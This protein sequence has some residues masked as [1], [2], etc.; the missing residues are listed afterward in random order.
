M[1]EHEVFSEFPN[2]MLIQ[3]SQ[4]CEQTNCQLTK[5]YSH[6]PPAINSMKG[7]FWQLTVLQVCIWGILK[8]RHSEVLR[9]VNGRYYHLFNGERVTLDVHFIH[10]WSFSKW[11]A[12]ENWHTYT[13]VKK[14]HK[15]P[16][17]MDAGTMLPRMQ[18]HTTN[19]T[20]DVRVSNG[21]G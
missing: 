20:H 18:P 4:S 14:K 11:G 8:W 7:D 19:V 12:A 17:W 16:L 9:A 1:E 6:S 3:M 15:E 13:P 21:C 2:K 5:N 10:C